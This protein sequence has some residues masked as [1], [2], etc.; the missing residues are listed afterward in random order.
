[1][2]RECLVLSRWPGSRS[3]LE[4]T[5]HSLCRCVRQTAA[6]STSPE[7]D[8]AQPGSSSGPDKE[9]TQHSPDGSRG[10]VSH[11]L[12]DLRE[13]DSLAAQQ[14]WNRYFAQLVP[15]A[16][17]RLARL[18]RDQSGED[19]ALSAMKSLMIGIQD[20]RYP[21]LDDRDGLWPLLVTITARKAISEQRRQL[22]DKRTPNRECRIDDVQEYVG[23]EPTPE[24][25]VEVAD[26]LERLAE[27][28]ADSDLKRIVELKLGGYTN[29]EI[30]T[31]LGCTSRTIT[32]KLSRIREE[33]A[34]MSGHNL[35]E[36][37]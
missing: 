24:F 8:V 32:R 23:T 27:G 20:N 4:S 6:I 28:L 37:L 10:S 2:V 34:V 19:I 22:T 33:W 17:A 36:V 11:W 18:T 15:I 14:L 21:Q 35:D 13:G 29:D 25:A 7:V 12:I 31:D 26:E 16:K 3:L 9:T 30:A 1:M 5:L